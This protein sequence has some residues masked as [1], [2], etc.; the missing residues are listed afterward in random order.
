MDVGC[1]GNVKLLTGCTITSPKAHLPQVTTIKP[2]NTSTENP[3]FIQNTH[4]TNTNDWFVNAPISPWLTALHA[5][6]INP[7]MENNSA[8]F[9]LSN[10][11]GL[12]MFHNCSSLFPTLNLRDNKALKLMPQ[13]TVMVCLDGG[14]QR[15]RQIIRSVHYYKWQIII[16]SDKSDRNICLKLFNLR[17]I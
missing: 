12:L 10:S 17:N 16:T 13:Y 4:S 5:Y 11:C 6:C 2:S 9:V 1:R 7:H 8:N 15:R 14:G 3:R